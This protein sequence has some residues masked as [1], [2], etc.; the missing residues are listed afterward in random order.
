MAIT[1]T[2]QAALD[3]IDAVRIPGGIDPR[4][5]RQVAESLRLLLEAGSFGPSDRVLRRRSRR[6]RA[7][8]LVF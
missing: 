7:R 4:L 3:L 6:M 2:T 8:R 1:R 5:A